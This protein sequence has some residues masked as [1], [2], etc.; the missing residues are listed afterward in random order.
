M[1]PLAT[2][3]TFAGFSFPRYIPELTRS[4][5]DKRTSRSIYYHAPKPLTGQPHPST[6]FYLD[7]H[8]SFN[9][10]QWADEVNGARVNHTGWYSDEYGD[11]EKIRGLVVCLPHG[12]FLAGWSMGEGMASAVEGDLYI[13]IIEAAYAADSIAEDVAERE[14]EYREE[15]RELEEQEERNHGSDEEETEGY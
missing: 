8:G 6:G 7:N 14:R 12:K 15:Q 9:R 10:W 3:F 5:Y 13:D 4:K 2:E 11:A 1:T